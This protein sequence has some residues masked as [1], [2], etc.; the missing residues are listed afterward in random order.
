MA[1]VPS[2]EAVNPPESR[3]AP[4]RKKPGRK[5]GRTHTARLDFRLPPAARD[6]IEKAALLSGQSLSDFAASILVREAEAL[7]EKQQ[8]LLLSQRAWEQ[9]S[10]LLRHPSAPTAAAQLQAGR[11]AQGTVRG[12]TYYLPGDWATS[13]EGEA[14]DAGF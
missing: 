6:K 11:M 7:L 2:P 13:H 9:F 3:S 10:S 1:A 12:D 4:G 8:N 14:I 5:P